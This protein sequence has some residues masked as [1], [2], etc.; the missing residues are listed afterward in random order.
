MSGKKPSG[1]KGIRDEYRM[2]QDL[3]RDARW[4]ESVMLGRTK[5]SGE[6]GA[7]VDH[8]SKCGCGCGPVSTV[9][10]ERQEDEE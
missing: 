5:R 9:K 10:T 1:R 2:G 3:M 6:E 4:R 7:Y 8:Y